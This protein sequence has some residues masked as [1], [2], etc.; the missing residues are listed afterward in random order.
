MKSVLCPS[1]GSFAVSASV[2][3]RP[4]YEGG[5]S[6]SLRGNGVSCHGKLTE[7]RKPSKQETLG[8]GLAVELE[9][10]RRSA[11]T[12]E[13]IDEGLMFIR[14]GMSVRFDEH[15]YTRRLEPDRR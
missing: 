5:R 13:L 8:G 14:F 12:H 11:Y 4:G 7:S 1:V 10:W 15:L 9:I 6:V 3:K 2:W